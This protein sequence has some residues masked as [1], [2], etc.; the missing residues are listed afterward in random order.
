[1]FTQNTIAFQDQA[2]GHCTSRERSIHRLQRR[3]LGNRLVLV[4]TEDIVDA[5]DLALSALIFEVIDGPAA[6]NLQ[7]SSSPVARFCVVFQEQRAGL[8]LPSVSD[9]LHVDLAKALQ[10]KQIRSTGVN[11]QHKAETPRKQR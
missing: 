4:Q 11:S 3:R 5:L 9:A 1:M 6:D 8:G 7:G 10:R 2:S